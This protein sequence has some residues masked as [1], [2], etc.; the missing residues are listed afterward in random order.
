MSI[1]NMKLVSG[2]E[3]IGK[4]V[5]EEEDFYTVRRP[6]TI[7]IQ[8][9]SNGQAGAQFIP[10]LLL[11]SD[12]EKIKVMKNAIIMINDKV[13]PEYVRMYE[14]ATTEIQLASTLNG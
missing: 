1:V 6:R 11:S 12:A 5:A 4:I 13:N 9:M 7:A 10:V 3:I 2:E 14:Q 8:Q